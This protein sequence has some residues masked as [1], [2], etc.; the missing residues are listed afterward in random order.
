MILH[1][2]KQ[3]VTTNVF[4]RLESDRVSTTQSKDLLKMRH[5][6]GHAIEVRLNLILSIRYPE[7]PPNRA[8]SIKA[9]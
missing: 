6:E 5:Q 7:L 8:K 2:T 3:K 9:Y 4:T 1:R